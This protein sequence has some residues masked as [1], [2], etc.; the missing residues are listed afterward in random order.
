MKWEGNVARMR[1][2]RYACT[3]SI[4]KYEGNSQ[5]GKP[6]RNGLIKLNEIFKKKGVRKWTRLTWL[7]MMKGRGFF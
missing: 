1:D 6:K 3:A 7:M 2:G 5:L 4:G